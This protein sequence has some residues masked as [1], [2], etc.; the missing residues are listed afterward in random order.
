MSV[1]HHDEG[2]SWVS[3]YIPR[4]IVAAAAAE[5]RG[6]GDIWHEPSWSGINHLVSGILGVIPRND[7]AHTENIDF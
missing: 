2:P 3:P 5:R 1:G 6:G 7:P 4:S